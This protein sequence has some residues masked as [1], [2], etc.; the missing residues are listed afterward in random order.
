MRCSPY[1]SALIPVFLSGPVLAQCV[2]ING[3]HADYSFVRIDVD[4][5]NIPLHIQDGIYFGMSAW[6]AN[7]CNSGRNSHPEFVTYYQPGNPVIQ[8]RYYDDMA[9][10][11]G[12]C[13]YWSPGRVIDGSN[14]TISLYARTMLDGVPFDCYPDSEVVGDDVAH[15]LGHYLG[16][17]HSNCNGYIMAPPPVEND[18]SPS[19]QPGECAQ[20]DFNNLTPTEEDP[21]D[22][23]GGSGVNWTE[24]DVDDG[25]DGGGDDGGGADSACGS[26]Q[27]AWMIDCGPNGTW[28]YLVCLDWYDD[29]EP[30][31]WD[32]CGFME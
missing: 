32:R 27:K 11:A 31:A 18:A 28:D 10:D 5:T 24:G 14:S 25:G 3:H 7:A 30:V 6:N 17:G 19:V 29:P 20:A 12:I 9:P 2:T 22:E 15:E 13:A 21:P 16:L 23:G 4:M 8:L 26:G 1:A